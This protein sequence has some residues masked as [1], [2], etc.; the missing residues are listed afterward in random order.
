MREDISLA[1]SGLIS[2]RYPGRYSW[3]M[4]GARDIEE[5]LTEAARSTSEA[6]DR[7]KMQ[8]WNGHSYETVD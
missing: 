6:I 3:I 8:V 7:A 4:I 5:A 2:Y 1:A